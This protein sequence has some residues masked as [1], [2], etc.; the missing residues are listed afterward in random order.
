MKVS[1]KIFKTV[2]M[3]NGKP[4]KVMITFALPVFISL[5]LSNAFSLINSLVLK[6]TVGGNAVTA[7]SAT[8]SISVILFNFAYGCSN[9]FSVVSANKYGEKDEKAIKRIFINALFLIFIIGFII[10]TIGMIFYNDLISFLNVDK[11]YLTMAEQ[12]YRIILLTFVF[13]LLSNYL[14]HFLRGLGNSISPLFISVVTTL[15]NIIFAFLLTGVIKINTRGVALATFLSNLLNVILSFIYIFKKYDYLK[16][17]FKDIKLDKSILKDLL[18]MGLPLG[19]QWSILF[20]GGFIQSRTINGFGKYATK[21]VSCYSPMET[22]LTI[23]FSALSTTTLAFMSQN[24]GASNNDRIKN[25]LKSSLTIV[26][27]AY[28][29]ITIIGFLTYKIVPYIFLPKEEVTKDVLYYAT[30]YLKVLIPCIFLQGCLQT[31]RST[32]LGIKKPLIPL[33]SGIGELVARI[34]ICLFLPTIVDATNPF[35]QKSYLSIC[36]ATPCAWLVSFLIMG[37]S[38]LHFIKNKQGKRQFK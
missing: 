10:S 28:I 35:S 9:G 34:S 19:L 22:Y 8:G 31:F 32:L 6:I 24:Y 16:F 25:G 26:F 29:I 30:T 23:P 12:Y 15:S 36:F 3:T 4:Y 5:L 33:I 21:A 27:F 11:I 13:M 7:I 37:I 18:K 20:I 17:K 38:V 1:K 14:S 2:D